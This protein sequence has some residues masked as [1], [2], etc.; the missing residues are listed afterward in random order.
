MNNELSA[1][2]LRELKRSVQRDRESYSIAAQKYMLGEMK[3]EG[4]HQNDYL[5][6]LKEFDERIAKLTGMI[7]AKEK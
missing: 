6:T 3:I 5:P 4:Y 7:Q 1:D 2:E